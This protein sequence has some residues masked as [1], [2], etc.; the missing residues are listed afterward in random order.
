[1]DLT[2]GYDFRKSED[3]RKAWSEI[4]RTQPFVVMGYP[5]CTMFS[6]LQ[7]LNKF[8]HKDDP[9]W[10]EKFE[11]EKKSATEYLQFCFL[12]YRHQLRQGLR[13]FT[14]TL[15]VPRHGRSHVLAS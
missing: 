14:S 4:K 8:I 15:G 7:E 10:L 9:V 3:R 5:P 11:R 12:L 2:N 6:S 1:M 13:F